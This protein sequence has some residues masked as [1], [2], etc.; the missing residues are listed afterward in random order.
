PVHPG[1]GSCSARGPEARIMSCRSDR[2]AACR[3][4]KGR[5]PAEI[6]SVSRPG[7][8]T[9]P[10]F[11]P[12]SMDSLFRAEFLGRLFG[13]AFD[14][15]RGE[16][17]AFEDLLPLVGL[18]ELHQRFVELVAQILGILVEVEA[19]PAARFL[20]VDDRIGEIGG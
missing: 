12:R 15:G 1:G 5:I 13:R 6:L 11:R 9:G 20:S 18:L 2:D 3:A 16:A 7:S 14:I 8:K 19:A 4:R 10:E 17:V